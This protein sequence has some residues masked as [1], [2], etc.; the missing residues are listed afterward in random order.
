MSTSSRNLVK[1]A[2]SF[3]SP[4]RIPRQLWLLPWATDRYPDEVRRIK[5][6]FPDDIVGSPGFLKYPYRIVGDPYAI[7]MYVDEWGCIF[8]NRQKGVIGEVKQ[9]LIETWEKADTFNP[10]MAALSV[11][12]EQVNQFCANTDRF[13]LAGCCPRPF[14]R[15]Q[16]LRG[17]MNLYLDLGENS[18]EFQSLLCKV[19][20]FYLKEFELWAKTNVDGLMFMDD[21]GAQQSLLISPKQWRIHFKPLYQEYIDVAHQ[22]GKFVFMHSDGYIADIIPDLVEMGLDALNSQLFI[23]DIE[24]LGRQFAGKITFWGEIDRQHILRSPDV[25]FARQ[26]VCRVYSAFWRLGGCIAQCEFSAGARPEN[27]WAVYETWEMLVG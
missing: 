20:E 13:V 22:N 14:E 7:G 3:D 16:F 8:E 2:L 11:D 27:V 18:P 24:N 1:K 9:P 17:S 19:H 23:M 26:A 15:L 25:D 21:W 10:P 12:T 6:R 5:E 4:E